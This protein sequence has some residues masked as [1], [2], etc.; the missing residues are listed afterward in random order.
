MVIYLRLHS[1][2][3]SEKDAKMN[4]KNN[5]YNLLLVFTVFKSFKIVYM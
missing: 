3:Q 1:R 4:E 2:T 5:Q